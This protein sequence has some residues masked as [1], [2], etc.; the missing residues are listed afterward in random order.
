[1]PGG[2]KKPGFKQAGIVKIASGGWTECG[3]TVLLHR[4]NRF[5]EARV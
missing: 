1:M 5:N 2:F 4:E 3:P